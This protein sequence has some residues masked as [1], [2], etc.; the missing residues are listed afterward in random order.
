MGA[1]QT[2]RFFLF[3]HFTESLSSTQT[4]VSGSYI[5]ALSPL[6][7]CNELQKEMING[8]FP[9]FETKVLYA[10]DSLSHTPSCKPAS[11]A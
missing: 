8:L 11:N 4:S 6:R 1:E 10:P 7:L 3:L 2:N 5:N 9:K